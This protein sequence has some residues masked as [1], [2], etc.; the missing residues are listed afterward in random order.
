M[1]NVN[2]PTSF[3]LEDDTAWLFDPS[4]PRKNG[5]G[6]HLYRNR[7]DGTFEETTDEAGVRWAG[8]GAAG[9]VFFDLDNDGRQDLFVANGLWSA[10]PSAKSFD[11]TFLLA[12]ATEK[13]L[14]AMSYFFGL[15]KD[16]AFAPAACRGCAGG[17]MMSAAP[18]RKNAVLK[19]L[20]DLRDE[21]GR[22]LLSLGG[23]Q[24]NRLFLNEGDGTF[25]DIAYVAGAD[26]AADGYVA[27]TAELDRDGALQLVL[28][29]GDPGVE[30]ASYPTVQL[31]RNHAAK[32]N[33][34]L[35]FRLTG[36]DAARALARR[37]SW[38]APAARRSAASSSPTT[39][40]PKTPGSCTSAWAATP[41]PPRACAGRRGA[42]R[43]SPPCPPAPTPWK[44]AAS[45]SAS[46]PGAWP[47]PGSSAPK[48]LS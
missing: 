14:A 22:P 12:A 41:R 8:A 19:L 46:R 42:S 40:R 1:T 45:P 32:G 7:G 13:H 24:R 10:G 21:G 25:T 3:V 33:R 26:S 35:V 36:R 43:S 30:T 6:N 44:R 16:R 23:D 37:S 27:A 20:R 47:P 9:A 5:L 17:S 11:A 15:K 31:Y 34:H 38:S 2:F 29:N 48:A 18:G 39:A 4:A 28:R